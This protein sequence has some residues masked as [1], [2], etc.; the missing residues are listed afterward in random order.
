VISNTYLSVNFAGLFRMLTPKSDTTDIVNL[1]FA[2]LANRQRMLR[3]PGKVGASLQ[4]WPFQAQREIGMSRWIKY[5]E[6]GNCRE[7][8]L[9]ML[10]KVTFAGGRFW[11]AVKLPCR[12]TFSGKVECSSD[13]TQARLGLDGVEW[14]QGP[15]RRNVTV[16]VHKVLRPF[17]KFSLL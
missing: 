12:C 13:A 7:I 5:P 8:C 16:P 2:G 1:G 4:L 14:L 10:Q 17:S 15:Q 6:T 3:G 9:F 11:G